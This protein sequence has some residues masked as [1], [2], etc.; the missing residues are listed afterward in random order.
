MWKRTRYGSN[1]SVT[2]FLSTENW[3][4]SISWWI[5]STNI[6]IVRLIWS[7][8][9]VFEFFIFNSFIFF[10]GMSVLFGCFVFGD[11]K[12]W[13]CPISELYM[14]L[15]GKPFS[16]WPTTE[17]KLLNRTETSFRG[18]LIWIKLSLDRELWVRAKKKN[19]KVGG[20]EG[21]RGGSRK[22][23]RRNSVY[24]HFCANPQPQTTTTTATNG[25]E[26]FPFHSLRLENRCISLDCHLVTR[27]NSVHYFG[28]KKK[29]AWS[30]GRLQAR[31]YYW[32]ANFIMLW[33]LLHVKFTTSFQMTGESNWNLRLCPWEDQA[34]VTQALSPIWMKL[35]QIE[36][37]TQ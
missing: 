22:K 32:I 36:G 19:T 13:L 20:M 12:N 23:K 35:G 17:C 8:L 33:R 31:K 14:T 9:S 37:P 30:I 18:A 2:S 21:R 1:Y 34:G 3:I 24:S 26:A 7:C 29:K 25:S 10:P 28:I 4:Y 16:R 15:S 6:N 5:S 27:H 11:T